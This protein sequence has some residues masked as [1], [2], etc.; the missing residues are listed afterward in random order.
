MKWYSLKL[1]LIVLSYAVR[2]DVSVVS[3]AAGASI[4]GGAVTLTW[5]DSG[6][7]PLLAAIK[8][9]DI[10]LC[11]GTNAAIV[12]QSQS[13]QRTSQKDLTDCIKQLLT[14]LAAAVPMGAETSLAMT[15]PVTIG[16]NGQ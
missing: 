3:P 1:A 15:I 16:A 14:T 11:T 5:T 13:E 4:P 7:N 12:S 9:A 8:V 6:A 10:Q 2:G